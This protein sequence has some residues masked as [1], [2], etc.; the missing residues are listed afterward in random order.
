MPIG[1]AT[2]RVFTT[3]Y[4]NAKAVVEKTWLDSLESDDKDQRDATRT[5]S[6]ST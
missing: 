3:D 4:D 6:G 2:K 5:R 1:E